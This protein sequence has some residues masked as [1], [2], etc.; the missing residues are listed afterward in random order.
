MNI[1]IH[2]I[3]KAD[4]SHSGSIDLVASGMTSTIGMT[5]SNYADSE[6]S[7]MATIPYTIEV[8]KDAMPNINDVEF[9]VGMRKKVDLTAIGV[10]GEIITEVGN[11][12]GG[13]DYPNKV[14][15]RPLDLPPGFTQLYKG[16]QT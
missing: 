13:S 2:K 6:K 16:G 9:C 3:L 14:P 1:K 7:V 8:V 4:L 15:H 5:I 10:N 11:D 12:V